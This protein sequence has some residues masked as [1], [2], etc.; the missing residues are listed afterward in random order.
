[1]EVLKTVLEKQFSL[2]DVTEDYEI[3]HYCAGV[4]LLIAGVDAYGEGFHLVQ[5]RFTLL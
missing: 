3:R 5:H 4:K 1:M 2:R